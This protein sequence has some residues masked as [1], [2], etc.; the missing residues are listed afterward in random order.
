MREAILVK[1]HDVD[2]VMSAG[3][4]EQE[5]LLK[6]EEKDG[7]AEGDNGMQDTL[8]ENDLHGINLQD[9]PVMQELLAGQG[10]AMLQSGW[11][12]WGTWGTED[13]NSCYE[14]GKDGGDDVER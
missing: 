11:G 2:N 5:S 3:T 12:G 13:A 14:G 7:G 10:G 8:E 4:A 1:A 9:D 6:A